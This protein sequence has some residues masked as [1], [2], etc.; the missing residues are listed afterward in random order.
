MAKRRTDMDKNAFISAA[1]KLITDQGAND[2]SLADLAKA[3]GIS[4]GTLYYHYPTKDELILDIIEEHM[5]ELS[6]DYLDWFSRHKDDA[7]SESRFLD[8]VFYKGVKLFNRSKM[9]I[10]LVNE[11]MRGNSELKSRYVE[12][13]E[14][15]QQKLLEGV[16]KVFPQN[17]D[18]AGL[19]YTM[20]LILDGMVM[21]DALGH[22][23]EAMNERMKA[24]LIEK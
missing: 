1:E 19:A 15:W 2:F 7:I 16:K 8:V 10:Y 13:W 23:N 9:Q 12:L 5:N 6:K 24:I 11:C 21:E 18:Q 17:E 14:S 20:M 22:D 3:M 4:K